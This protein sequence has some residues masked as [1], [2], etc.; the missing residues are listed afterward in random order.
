M[1]AGVFFKSLH[2]LKMEI[3]LSF[4]RKVGIKNTLLPLR[5][6]S[7]VFVPVALTLKLIN[8]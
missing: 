4:G 3:P 2:F 5:L 7:A 6:H 8:R 1:I